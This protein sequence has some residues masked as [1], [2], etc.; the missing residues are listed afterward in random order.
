MT[1]D[2]ALIIT[3]ISGL[4]GTLFGFFLNE[5]SRT[6]W[7]A[8]ERMYELE[9]EGLKKLYTEL[10]CKS[11]LL[12]GYARMNRKV[13]EGSVEKCQQ[14]IHELWHEMKYHYFNENP[15]ENTY[16]IREMD[17]CKTRSDFQKCLADQECMNNVRD[18]VRKYIFMAFVKGDL[19]V[20]NT[21]AQVRLIVDGTSVLNE[22]KS[23]NHDMNALMY[24]EPNRKYFKNLEE[25]DIE[26]LK[27]TLQTRL[28]IINRG[29]KIE[30][31]NAR[32]GKYEKDARCSACLSKMSIGFAYCPHCGKKQG[33]VIY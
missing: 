1:D 29:S 16:S 23:L 2:L 33:I 12:V 11:D 24:K 17:N 9:V 20:H 4:I 26:E 3:G 14:E 31:T 5:R 28:D 6:K 27:G 18:E 32:K 25:W 15:I 7:N 30:L 22:A 8:R 13:D 10:R 21:I 19:A